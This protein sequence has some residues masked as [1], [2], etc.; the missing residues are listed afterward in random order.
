MARWP[1]W[2]QKGR[3]F[4]RLG[5]AP[6]EGQLA[7]HLSG[8][9]VPTV[10]GA[11]RGGKTRW[12]G[13]EIVARMPWC[14]R[15]A[16]V[17]EE[18]DECEPEM[19][20]VY[21]GLRALGAVA[22]ASM[23]QTGKLQIWTRGGC[24]IE[25]VSMHRGS[26]ELTGRGKA[27]D[28]AALVEAGHLSFEDVL[29][30]LGRVA[31][32]DG[33]VLI[34]GRLLD[35]YGWFADFYRSFQGPNR[36]GGEVFRFPAWMNTAIYPAGRQDP[37]I[38]YLEKTMPE[39]EFERRVGAGLLPS[40]ARMYPEFA[41]ASHVREL[42]F[43]ADLPVELAVDAGFYP[44]HY[45]VLAVQ[46]ARESFTDAGGARYSAE[47]VRVIDEVWEHHLTHYDVVNLCR[48][49]EWWSKV[50]RA[51]GGHESRQHPAARSTE[52]T[53]NQL[54][55]QEPGDPERFVF[56]TFDA[57]RILDGVQRVKSFLRDPATS[58]PRLWVGT[59]CA[60]LQHELQAYR[61]RTDSKGHVLSE[62]PEDRNNDALDALRNWMVERFGLVEM[63]AAKVRHGQRRQ[64]VRG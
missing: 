15:V 34:S 41:Y 37:K 56:E 59:G 21:E 9:K 60:G 31:E 14:E 40:K 20:V 30:A 35:N 55:G 12:T 3:T 23:P 17:A 39:D 52:E 25:T 18:Y 19:R 10:V 51:I 16:V 50:R 22:R 43:D 2:G 53:W 33:V 61:R 32:V 49:R 62:E 54:V 27:D 4:E 57:G 45:A 44:S 64:A 13:M 29:A 6:H 26:E 24:H 47:V 58:E 7:A 8:A 42:A 5:Y 48:Q 63:G 28:V 1:S 36:F 38:A 11:E 46:V